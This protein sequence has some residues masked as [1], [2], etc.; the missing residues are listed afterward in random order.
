MGF[1]TPEGVASQL[2]E[3]MTDW[4]KSCGVE[5]DDQIGIEIRRRLI[6]ARYVYRNR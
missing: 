4:A 5:I 3:Y 1:I 6:S 2:D